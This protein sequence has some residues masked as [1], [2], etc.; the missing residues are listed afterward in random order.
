MAKRKFPPVH[1]GVLPANDFLKA[2][3]GG[4]NRLAKGIC[5]PPRRLNEN[6]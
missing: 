3:Q 1:P 5:I 4:Q 6:R 2:L